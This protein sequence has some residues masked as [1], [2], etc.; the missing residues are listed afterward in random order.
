MMHL[1][2][3]VL[4]SLVVVP[5]V[6]GLAVSLLPAF[7]YLPALGGEQLS[8]QF[9]R[10]LANVPGITRS[11]SISLL[12]G[13][14]TPFIALSAVMLFLATATG[15]RFDRWVRRLISP[16]L[17]I[18]H[19][20]AAFG[21]AFL[22]APSGFLLRLLAPLV[23]WERAPDLL[24][25]ND[26]WGLAMML[27]LV[28]KEIPFLLL[29]ALAA[30]PQ[31][32]ASERVAIAR[33]LGY[34]PAIAWLKVVA[35]ALYPLLRLP[36]FAVI[37]FASA[38]VDVALILGP[39]LPPT[40][41]VRLL[42]WFSDPDLSRRFLAAAAAV[43]QLLISLAA[44]ALW[45]TAEKLVGKIWQTW[46]LGG[47]RTAGEVPLQLVGRTVVPLAVLTVSLSLVLLL[48]N[49]LA[50]LWSF[51]QLL[52]DDWTL[53]DWQDAL[54]GLQ[55]PLLNTLTIALL[56]TVSA[57]ILVVASLESEQRQRNRGRHNW[58]LLY[59]PL[60]L[61]QVVFL[62]GI[63]LLAEALGQQPG[64]L[65]VTLGHLLF[66]LPY[67]FISLAESYRRLDPRW[68][69]LAASL[70]ASRLRAW[71]R[72]RLPL[73]LAPMLTA[74]ALGFAISVSLYL[75]TQLLGAGRLMTVTTE[76]VALA[77]GGSASIIAVWAVIQALLPMLAF[78]LALL[79]PRFIWRQRSGMQDAP[80]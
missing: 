77:S 43:L 20:A 50:G 75:P 56:A 2:P 36:I 42:E 1:I 66:V 46:I 18:P 12:A 7:G 70:G 14:I 19:A 6:L 68:M 65:L 45:I 22:I 69:Q 21:L 60:L 15:G 73:L 13:L 17:A 59:V 11:A 53:R 61:P 76:A 54:A 74:A 24:L 33:S 48:V 10:Q 78:G 79:L 67:L 38:T 63:V 4:L 71:W 39:T 47:N 26:S 58:W 30:L 44:I 28:I 57:L 80:R 3:R 72:I 8:L 64:L 16:V 29:M 40:L 49:S 27:G 37:A 32:Q 52:P 25:V 41:S 51:P 5:V 9:W 34:R 31:I 62:F 55:L 35:P 23:G